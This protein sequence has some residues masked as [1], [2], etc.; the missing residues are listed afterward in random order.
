MLMV[1]QWS[2]H[3]EGG[4]IIIFIFKESQTYERHT[5]RGHV[6]QHSMVREDYPRTESTREVR[7]RICF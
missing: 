2:S 3:S 7:R 4:A 1:A 5:T 6:D